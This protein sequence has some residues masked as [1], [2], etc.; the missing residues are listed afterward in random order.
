[1]PSSSNLS[2][3]EIERHSSSLRKSKKARSR[4]PSKKSS[5]KST[6]RD[7]GEISSEE[8]ELIIK[9][10]RKHHSKSSRSP[11]VTKSRKHRSKKSRSRSRSSSRSKKH[12]SKKSRSA[13]RESSKSSRKHH[14]RN[15]SNTEDRHKHSNHRR[16][17]HDDKKNGHQSKDHE[18]VSKSSES[19]SRHREQEAR[20]KEHEHQKQRE[21][22]QRRRQAE[23]E[24]KYREE[25]RARHDHNERNSHQSHS[26]NHSHRHRSRSNDRRVKRSRSNENGNNR[27]NSTRERADNYRNGSYNKKKEI[28]PE[29]EAHNENNVD[30]EDDDEI[31]DIDINSEEEDEEAIIE[32]RRKERERLLKKLK[33]EFN[34]ETQVDENSVDS[35]TASPFSRQKESA[36]EEEPDEDVEEKIDQFDF[37]ETMNAKKFTISSNSASTNQLQSLTNV[38]SSFNSG[39]VNKLDDQELK[40][41]IQE[42]DAEILKEKKM[43]VST[44]DMFA[45][46][47]EYETG[48]KNNAL[49]NQKNRGMAGGNNGSL[50][51]DNWDDSEGY[52]KINIGEN[53][54]NQYS[55]YSCTGQGVFSNVVRARDLNKNNLEVAIKII[56]NNHITHKSGIK[57]LEYLNKLKEADP[58]DKFHCLRLFD[59]FYHKQHLCIVLE[60]LSMNLREVLKKYGKN[61]GL[62]I[63]AVR[64]YARQLFRALKLLKKCQILHADIKPDN[65]LV[66]E[67]KLVLKLCDFGSASDASDCDITEYL[68]S[69]F[70]RA[71]EIIMGMPYEYGIDLWSVAVTLYELYTG[72]IMFNGRSNNEMLKQFM[73]FRGKMSNKFIKRA[74]LKEKHFDSDCNFIFMETDKITKL[75]KV[76]VLANIPVTREL[77][78][79]ITTNSRMP[80]DQAKKISQLRD[81]LDKILVI[82]TT[83]RYTIRQAIAHPFVDDKY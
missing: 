16:H 83:K 29:K 4:S 45:S 43:T 27:H 64:S 57:E 11:S 15:K 24:S 8:E 59:T 6:V 14:K 65:I 54:N 44:F 5:S 17:D 47:D 3:M 9:K 30:D 10:K 31:Q 28:K 18:T 67:S 41:G 46:D 49:L 25:A 61:V 56:R 32:R 38:S 55:V 48:T 19:E 80:D 62:H 20:M 77:S 53:L 70:Y 82:D 50:L 13:S 60:P 22:D 72:K 35:S 69:R 42:N 40:N 52:Y 1:M 79:D 39:L 68:V 75:E 2:E 73:D 12:R 23:H 33:A 21:L 63:T 36:N 34:A 76:S 26:R 66:N 37:E 7:E 81:L 71:P 51:Y 58:E 74:V 78:K